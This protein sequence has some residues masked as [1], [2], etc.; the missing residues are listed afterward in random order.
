MTTRLLFLAL[1]FAVPLSAQDRSAR[2]ETFFDRLD[3]NVDGKISKSELEASSQRTAWLEKADLDK[4][5]MVNRE[6]VLGFF[7]K[8]VPARMPEK[9][10]IEVVRTSA[11]PTDTKITED[12]LK[13]AEKYSADQEGHGFLVMIDGKVVRESSANGWDPEKGHRLAS[14]TKSFSAGILALAVKDGLLSVEDKVSDTITEWKA[15]ER[16]SD[17]TIHD[18]LNLTSGIDPGENGRVPSYAEAV[19]VAA[20]S[21][22]GEKFRYGPSAFQ[23][24]GELIRRELNSRED[25]PF[26]DPLAY[27]EARVFEPIGLE[28][29]D[30]RRDR[31]GRP[32]LP[33]GAF[34]TVSEWAKYGQFL[35]Q[36]GMWK[37]EQLV[38]RETLKLAADPGS[39][40]AAG[41]GLTFWLMDGPA[42]A[43][44]PYLEGG[45]MAA[46]A[47]KQRLIVLPEANVVVVRQGES[48]Q[49]D[50]SEFLGKLFSGQTATSLSLP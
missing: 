43:G 28:Y 19:D 12:G 4:D 35:L 9:A 32:H 31:D 7:E 2:L 34:L 17:I 8:S 48:R 13:A 33:S 3:K 27:L 29:A 23:I 25:L 16:L 44:R 18:L 22:R 45:Y 38:D 46:G 30:W 21:G 14:G 15:D 26:E 41:Y 24:F 40:V 6:E 20:L 49:F 50:N 42:V 39:E 37:E 36:G 11:L 5:G 10:E 47:G 1:L